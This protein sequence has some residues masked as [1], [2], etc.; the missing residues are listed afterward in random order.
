MLRG[1]RVKRVIQGFAITVTLTL[2]QP[3][4]APTVPSGGGS[5][6][7]SGAPG[8]GYP[9]GGRGYPGVRTASR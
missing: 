1:I 8:G 4:V 2:N 6:P 5:A 9:G 3:P 7:K